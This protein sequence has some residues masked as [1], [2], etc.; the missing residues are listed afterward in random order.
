MNRQEVILDGGS[1]IQRAIQQASENA[2]LK[3]KPGVYK[4]GVFIDKSIT[5]RGLSDSVS[6]VILDGQDAGESVITIHGKQLNIILENLAIANGSAEAGGG[7]FVSSGQHVEIRGCLIRDN[8]ADY[9]GGGGIYASAGEIFIQNTYF[10]RNVGRHGGGALL[11]GSVQASIQDTVFAQNRGLRGGGVR[12]KENATVKCERCTF[13]DNQLEVGG[14]GTA[15]YI[16]GTMSWKPT[17]ELSDS[18]LDSQPGDVGL[19]NAATYPG[20]VAISNSLLP[21]VLERAEFFEDGGNNRYA[22]PVFKQVGD[23]PYVLESEVTNHALQFTKNGITLDQDEY[24]FLLN[25]LQSPFALGI[26]E[27]YAEIEP[28]QAQGIMSKAFHSLRQKG[29]VTLFPNGDWGIEPHI[30]SSIGPCA[31]S[32]ESLAA[33]YT[34]TQ[35]EPEQQDIRFFHFSQQS[36][37]EDAVLSGGNRQL[38]RM[39][40]VE[41]VVARVCEQFHLHK[42]KAAPG[43]NCTVEYIILE[44]IVQTAESEEH[45]LRQLEKVGVNKPLSITLAR[46][47]IAPVSTAGLV[48]TNAEK[49][50]VDQGLSILQVTDGLLLIHPLK[51]AELERVE[52]MPCDAATIIQHITDYVSLSVKE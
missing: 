37:I 29:I 47:I 48:R 25:F 26:E 49:G 13:A 14:K 8:E 46:A 27:S 3:L 30:Q 43:Q 35:V 19:F 12:I 16:S 41:Q 24:I 42:Q 23:N 52:I 36:I 20:G 2:V 33:T 6:E 5:L 31:S 50:R 18:I 1:D 38:T 34:G 39:Q 11:D 9:Y 32:Q 4:G 21:M 22:E 15:I 51:D 7:I 17:L 10:L 45:T 44:R 40:S 28:D